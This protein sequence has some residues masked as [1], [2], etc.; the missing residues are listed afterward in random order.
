MSSRSIKNEVLALL[1]GQNLAAITEALE[2][3]APKDAVNVLFSAICREDPLVRWFAV[4]CMGEAVARLAA[5]E[6]E[7]A[8]IVMRRFLWS[9]NDESGGIGWGVPESM[10]EAMCRHAGLAEE[11]VHMLISYMREDGEEICQDSNYIEHPLLQRG[12]L[13]GV[14]RMS[15][16]RPR[17]LV[18]RGAGADIPPYLQ[19][20]DG[21]T[22]GLAVLVAGHL[23]LNAT[24]GALRRLI[25]D[26]TPLTLY[27][28][29]AF[30]STMV[31]ELALSALER[32]SE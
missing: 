21:E 26:T 25:Q 30:Q 24:E 4:S 7:E 23:H 3:Y 8:R 32:M 16:C 1:K 12:L 28:E 10:A 17:L 29:G 15:S 11:Y 2:R 31:G 13:W 9:L 6:M 18:E 20:E 14:A 27:W 5:Q 19:A 22:R